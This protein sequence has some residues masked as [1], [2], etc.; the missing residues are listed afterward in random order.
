[1]LIIA[2]KLAKEAEFAHIYL[3]A[4][5]ENTNIGANNEG[6]DLRATIKVKEA[7]LNDEISLV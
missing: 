6:Y 7:V 3:F 4:T 2:G 1:M 5:N